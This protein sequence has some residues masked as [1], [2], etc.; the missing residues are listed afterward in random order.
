MHHI[1]S[2]REYR[3]PRPDARHG[4]WQARKEEVRAARRSTGSHGVELADGSTA[5][6]PADQGKRILE[7]RYTAIDSSSLAADARAQQNFSHPDQL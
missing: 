7:R 2:F 5:L 3:D 1:K 4:G 6:P